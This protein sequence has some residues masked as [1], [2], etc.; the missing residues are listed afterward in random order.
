MSTIPICIDFDDYCDATVDQLPA[1]KAL[2]DK[3][4]NCKITL[5]TIPARCTEDT[6]KRAKD[7][8]PRLQLAPHGWR[9]TKGECLSWTDEE[10]KAKIERAA[11]MGIDAPVFR[12]PAWLLDADVYTACGELGYTVAS[13]RT[14]RVPNTGVPEYV[15]N[16]RP[17]G[18]R[19]R[20]IH[21]HVTPVCDNHISQ[22]VTNG[23]FVFKPG[24]Q[25][26]F[27]Q[28]LAT[29]ITDLQCAS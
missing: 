4:E 27:P 1:V 22:L 25:F 21:G 29:V 15:Y 9:H 26:V 11:E 17:P 6:I 8:G 18:V 5:F 2:L 7:L 20:A 28:E 12:A 3:D 13:H 16:Y 10:A 23:K 24:A 14:F 19:F